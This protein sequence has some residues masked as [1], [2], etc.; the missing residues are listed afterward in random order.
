ML[1]EG[2]LA[3]RGPYRALLARG[4]DFH[5][6]EQQPLSDDEAASP[7]APAAP[8]A[9][10]AAGEDDSAEEAEGGRRGGAAQQQQAAAMGP[11]DSAIELQS[12]GQAGAEGGA[13]A[14]SMPDASNGTCAAAETAAV[15]TEVPLLDEGGGAG[16]PQAGAQ[17]PSAGA[18]LQDG[19]G[20]GSQRSSQGGLDLKVGV[21]W[22][23]GC[24]IG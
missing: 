1:R 12:R 14:G 11:R 24:S 22:R 23:I 10:A 5:Q 13:A 3:E 2:R 4:V 21:G 17:P 8:A 9:G 19:G 20:G 7:T 15:F 6:F 18:Q 16:A